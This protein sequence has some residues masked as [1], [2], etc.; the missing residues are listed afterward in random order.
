M[1]EISDVPRA[2]RK[3]TVTTMR[4]ENF[5]EVAVSDTGPGIPMDKAEKVFRPF[6]TTKPKGIGMGMGLSI[7]RT[8]IEAHQGSIWTDNQIS[9]GAVFSHQAAA[10]KYG[11]A[12]RIAVR[13]YSFSKRRSS[14]LCG[15][16][17]DQR[18][19]RSCFP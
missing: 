18:P 17:Q 5:T 3:I 1:D 13:L 12:R 14:S 6:F 8:I 7:V 19:W 16:S 11:S 4:L 15:R 10:L 2:K 9:G